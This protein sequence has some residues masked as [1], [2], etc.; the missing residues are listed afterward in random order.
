MPAANDNINDSQSQN[1]SQDEII[2]NLMESGQLKLSQ[3]QLDSLVDRLLAADVDLDNDKV[4]ELQKKSVV[5]PK[6]INLP[7]VTT[8]LLI[9]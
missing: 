5:V 1:C 8:Q 7:L 4:L 6:K 3:S 9:N 2:A